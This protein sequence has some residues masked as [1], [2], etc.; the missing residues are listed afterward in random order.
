MIGSALRIT[1]AIDNCVLRPQ[2][3]QLRELI[4]EENRVWVES[5]LDELVRDLILP[6]VELMPED[7]EVG[8]IVFAPMLDVNR[9]EKLLAL[10]R[11]EAS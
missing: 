9:F 8:R 6:G 5:Q 1:I 4:T 3:E 11:K 7:G 10:L 2:V